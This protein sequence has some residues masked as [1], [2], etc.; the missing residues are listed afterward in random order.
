MSE[1]KLI[2]SGV[3][4]YI[5]RINEITEF[6]QLNILVELEKEIKASSLLNEQE[7]NIT[8]SNT[9]KNQGLSISVYFI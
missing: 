4:N 9:I 8:K 7:K 2:L 5:K 1:P 6:S 3:D